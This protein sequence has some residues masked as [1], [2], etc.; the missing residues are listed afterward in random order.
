MLQGKR[1]WRGCG[2]ALSGLAFRHEQSCPDP[3]GDGGPSGASGL[4]WRSNACSSS[5]MIDPI[6]DEAVVG[7]KP[8]EKRKSGE[9]ERFSRPPGFGGPAF[10]F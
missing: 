5:G 3:H 1:S 8:R 9:V 4:R 7:M 2:A 6:A 10:L